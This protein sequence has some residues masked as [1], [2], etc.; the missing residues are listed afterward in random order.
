MNVGQTGDP[1]LESFNAQEIT[2]HKTGVV[3]TESVVEVAYEQ[4]SFFSFF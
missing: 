1:L 4:I 2:E 3:E